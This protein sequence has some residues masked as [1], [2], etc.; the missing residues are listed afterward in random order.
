M[1]QHLKPNERELI[2]LIKFFRKRAEKLISDGELTPEY[3]QFISGC[4]KIEEQLLAHAANRQAIL[5]KQEKL[6]TMIED[7]ANCPNCQKNT[8]L[9]LTGKATHEKGWKSNKYKCRRC[10]I[11]FVWNKPNNPWD[12]VTF[13]EQYIG[14]LENMLALEG[15]PA[16][17]KAQSEAVM[18]QVKQSMNQLKPVLD[19]AD[20]EYDVLQHKDLEMDRMLHEFKNY[21]LIEKIRL[22]T[23]VP[24][25]AK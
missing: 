1:L 14:E 16:E 9:K 17:V 7:H 2:K 25:A 3:E 5:L 8:H 18:A 21:L 19:A 23:W 4:E 10:N 15:T 22:D 20:E 12:M 11:E 13:L 24:P 6:R